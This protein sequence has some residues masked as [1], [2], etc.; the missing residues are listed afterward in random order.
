[1]L[2]MLTQPA[3]EPLKRAEWSREGTAV[4]LLLLL[5]GASPVVL[6]Q[7]YSALRTALSRREAGAH[8]GKCAGCWSEQE[9]ADHGPAVESVGDA[10]F[11]L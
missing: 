11:P 1:M 8:Q 7:C 5:L 10:W 6:P 3:T 2:H 9:P 4:L